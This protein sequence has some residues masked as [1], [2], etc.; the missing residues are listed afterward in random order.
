[1]AKDRQSS[2]KEFSALRVFSALLAVFVFALGVVVFDLVAHRHSGEPDDQITRRT[3][4]QLE[5]IALEYQA[6]KGDLPF[7][8]L[9]TFVD[10][11][12]LDINFQY[13]VFD[14]TAYDG[15]TVYDAWGN[16]IRL[17]HPRLSSDPSI[18]E[19]P[20]VFFASSGEDGRWGDVTAPP[21]SDAH[22]PAQDNIRSFDDFR[23]LIRNS[24]SSILNP[25]P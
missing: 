23:P 8:D 1:M 22:R 13:K 16:E 3:I 24:A 10:E 9:R 21:G 6:Y 17:I 11:T 7:A 19:H 14:E 4:K 15:L 25:E 5:L 18:G 20:E 2:R 12:N